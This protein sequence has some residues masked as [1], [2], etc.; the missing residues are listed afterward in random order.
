MVYERMFVTPS[1]VTMWDLQQCGIVEVRNIA[2]GGKKLAH[3]IRKE[4]K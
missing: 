3:C 4:I 2:L 1:V